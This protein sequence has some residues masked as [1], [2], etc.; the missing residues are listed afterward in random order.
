MLCIYDLAHKVLLKKVVFT[1]NRSLD[2]VLEKLNSKAMKNGINTAEIDVNEDSDVNERR[3]NV[4]PGAKKYDYSKRN[5]KL[6]VA[7]NDVKFSSDGKAYAIA[8]PEGLLVY[9]NKD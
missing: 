1:E 2:G 6:E 3:D 9:S 7:I 5:V 8:T 4:L